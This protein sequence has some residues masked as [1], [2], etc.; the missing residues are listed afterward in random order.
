VLST[1]NV[2]SGTLSITRGGIGTTTLSANQI[3]IGNTTT[4]ILQSAN[5]TWNNTSNTLS[6][7]NFVGSG[8]GITSLNY[9][10]ILTNKPDLTLY[11]VKSNV[12]AS[13]NS[14]S[15]NKQY[16]FTLHKHI[17][18]RSVSGSHRVSVIIPSFNRFNFLM[19]AIGSIKSQTY[20]DIE[21]IVV[22]D[23]SSEKEYYTF[24]CEQFGLEKPTFVGTELSKSISN[25][26]SKKLLDFK[27]IMDNPYDYWEINY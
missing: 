17:M 6:A 23:C 26:K 3:L 11:A 22:N 15:T 8:S 14:L 27:Y 13:L 21:I 1:S 16:I 19:N 25:E 12:D 10:N 18:E 5:L 9:N 20:N 7:T 4:S 24:D 2:T